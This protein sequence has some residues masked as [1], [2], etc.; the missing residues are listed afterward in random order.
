MSIE[1]VRAALECREVRGVTRLVL[2]VLA[3]RTN[4]DSGLC[5]PSLETICR[6]ACASRSQVRRAIK[7]LEELGLVTRRA[8]AGR[9]RA[10]RYR[11]RLSALRERGHHDTPPRGKRCSSTPPERGSSCTAK[12][13][14]TAPEPEREPEDREPEGG[15]PLP[16]PPSIEEV[17]T[18]PVEAAL[19][20][21][22]RYPGYTPRLAKDYRR[23]LEFRFRTRPGCEGAFLKAIDTPH[24]LTADRITAALA[25]PDGF[26]ARGREDRFAKLVE[27]GKW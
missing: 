11:L 13:V 1:H 20:K 5:W 12:R 2:I 24:Y 4:R 14:T 17:E 23:S 18:N 8:A 10:T 19:D 6:E 25:Y 16:Q 27:L 15:D 26:L 22:A 7:Q 9:G 3:E 21:L